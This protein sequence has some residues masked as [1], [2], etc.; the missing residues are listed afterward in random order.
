MMKKAIRLTLIWFLL[1]CRRI[2]ISFN[3]G[4]TL[5]IRKGIGSLN[6]SVYYVLYKDCRYKEHALHSEKRG[7]V[8]RWLMTLLEKE[9]SD[10]A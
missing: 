8:V 6:R 3:D 10:E 1:E 9:D 2:R 4:R 7:E 5:S